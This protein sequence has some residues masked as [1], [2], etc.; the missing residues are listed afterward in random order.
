MTRATIALLYLR[1][2]RRTARCGATATRSIGSAYVAAV[3]RASLLGDTMLKIILAASGLLGLFVVP[4]LA[5][6]F[7]SSPI[8]PS[9]NAQHRD[10]QLTTF[11]APGADDTVAVGINASGVVVGYYVAKHEYGFVRSAKGTFTKFSAKASA[12]TYPEAVNN[13]GAIVGSY[14][15]N[16]SSGISHGFVR[17]ANGTIALFDPPGSVFTTPMAINSHGAVVGYYNDDKQIPHG[18]LRGAGGKITTIDFA[19]AKRGTEI[20]CI[21]KKGAVAGDYIDNKGAYH[22]FVRGAGGKFTS[23]D[24]PGAGK[25][26]NQGTYVYGINNGG[27]ISGYFFTDTHKMNHGFVRAADGTFTVFDPQGS[28]GTYLG[29]INATGAITGIYLANEYTTDGFVRAAD[30]TI[31]TFSAPEAAALGTHPMGINSNSVIV[32]TYY[33]EYNNGHGFEFTP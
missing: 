6:P 16:V 12:P 7:F 22:G 32:G 27:A 8:Y 2:E 3:P 10:S 5:N 26:K 30:G 23:F 15:D 20:W 1:N 13:N 25:K 28:V 31:T 18:F 14:E 19:G 21:N 29:Y 17:A 9:F 33:D 4:A 24:V 11:D